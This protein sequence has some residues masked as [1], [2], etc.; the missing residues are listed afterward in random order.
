[1]QTNDQAKRILCYGDSNTR[2][3]VPSSMGTERFLPSQRWPG[4]LQNVLGNIYEIIEEG[5]G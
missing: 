5:L 1:M 3:R 2:G 4:I